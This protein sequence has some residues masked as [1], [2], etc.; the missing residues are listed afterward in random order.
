MRRILDSGRSRW[1]VPVVLLAF[2][3]GVMTDSDLR[4]VR[5]V[6]PDVPTAVVIACV[7]GGSAIAYLVLFYIF[8]WVATIV[9][10]FLEGQG[11]VRDVRAALAWGLAPLLFSPIYNIPAAMMIHNMKLPE[12]GDKAALFDVISRGGCTYAL[13]FALLDLAFRIW[14]I[15]VAS[16]T[17]GEAHRFSS[18]RGLGVFV[19]AAIIPIIIAAAAVLTL[20]M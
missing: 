11:T 19:I 4:D 9:G 13:L 18:W 12:Q 14:Y 2:V 17:L 10:R 6:L 20:R 3:S 7:I 15:V 1:V 16:A 5:K 8:G